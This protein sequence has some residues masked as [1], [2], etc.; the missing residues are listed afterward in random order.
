VG[1]VATVQFAPD[2][3]RIP[4]VGAVAKA[5][6]RTIGTRCGYNNPA[7]ESAVE[8]R[9][10]ENIGVGPTDAGV[11]LYGI[12]LTGGVI[13]CRAVD[14]TGGQLNVEEETRSASATSVSSHVFRRGITVVDATSF[15]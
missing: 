9:A 7:V 4:A 12:L 6:S 11:Q 8:R 1:D 15:A 5:G 13:D 3:H 10:V 2:L 14:L